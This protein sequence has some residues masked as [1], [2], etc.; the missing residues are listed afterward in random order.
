[1]IRRTVFAFGPSCSGGAEKPCGLK[2]ACRPECRADGS[3]AGFTLLEVITAIFIFFCGIVGILSLF[4]TALMLHKTSLDRTV[5]ALT[6]EQAVAEVGMLLDEGVLL[7]RATGEVRPLESRPL[8]GYPGY[9][10]SAEFE[11]DEDGG[12]LMARIRISWKARGIEMSESFDYA[13]RSGSSQRREVQKL[14]SEAGTRS[15]KEL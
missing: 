10:F 15:S 1:M 8:K 13:F 2:S 12:G 5:S 3:E 11:G 4:T 14:R 9:F 6:L 7:D